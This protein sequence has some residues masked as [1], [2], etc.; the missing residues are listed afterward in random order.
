M[1]AST[2][3]LRRPFGALAAAVAASLTIAALTA[4][5]ESAAATRPGAPDASAAGDGPGVHRQYGTPVAVGNG[6]ARTY[7]VLDQRSGGR[8]LEVGVALDEAALEGLP[9]PSAAAHGGDAHA[10]MTVYDL[11]L[12]ARHGTPYQFVQLDWNPGGHEPPGVYDVPHFDFHFYTI[13]KAERDAIDPAVIGQAQYAARANRLP[14]EAER[15]DSYVP[16]GPPDAPPA[17]VAVPRMG[18][19]WGSLHAPE[20]Q[21]LF[22]RPEAARPF[23]TTFLRGSWDGRVHFDEPMVTRAFILGR[24]AATAPA[25]RDSVMP[26]PAAQ[27]YL[28]A[29][30][31]PT[32]YRV[33]YDAQAREYRIALTQ[34]TRRD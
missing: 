9:T 21:G 19:H 15:A 31:H 1:P 18:V 34:L 25:Q 11:E 26:L 2:H 29:G 7:V 20:L 5:S 22:G 4:C 10:G 30:A 8:P 3:P 17:A 24:K 23:T 33:A 32:A 6:R 16:L 12:P 28:P 27:R 13:S 14:P